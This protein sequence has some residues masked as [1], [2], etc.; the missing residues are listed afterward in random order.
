MKVLVIGGGGREHALVWKISQSPRVKKIF[1]APGNAGIA[2]L[3]ECATIKSEDL[4]G[5]LAYARAK[6]VDLTIVGPEGPLSLG[7]VDEFQRAGLRVFGP[8]RSAAEIEA[9]KAFTKD[10]MRKYHI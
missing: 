8:D 1:A 10:L 2:R 5:L 6:A 3:A 4:S 7:I 9:N